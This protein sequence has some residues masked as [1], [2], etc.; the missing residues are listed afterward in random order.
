MN[1]TGMSM[2]SKND[3]HKRWIRNADGTWI[4]EASLST[5]R[6]FFGDIAIRDDNTSNASV[7]KGQIEEHSYINHFGSPIEK[8]F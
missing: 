8:Q 6:P 4:N 7:A 5:A 2:S 3:P 1:L